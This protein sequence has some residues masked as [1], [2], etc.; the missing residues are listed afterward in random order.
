MPDSTVIPTLYEWSGGIERLR[1]LTETF[2]RKVRNDAVLGPV[3]AEMDSRHPEYVADFLAE[4][5]GG[6]RNYSGQR[7]GHPHMIGKHLNR[8]LD[9]AKR[10]RWVR[11]LLEAADDVGLPDDPEFRSAFVGY[12]EWGTRIAVINSQPGTAVESDQP[13]PKWG[14]GEVK[15]PYVPSKGAGV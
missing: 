14:W 15:G 6:P 11:L 4:V 8:H 9:E 1:Q 5:F 7:G 13:M 2:Y 12:I 3:F 10:R